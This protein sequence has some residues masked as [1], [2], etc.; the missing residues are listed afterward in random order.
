MRLRVSSEIKEQ[1]DKI[2]ESGR[3]N[4][5]AA[6]EVMVIADEMGFSELV[7]WIEENKLRYIEGIIRGFESD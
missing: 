6:E 7:C 3:T 4:M 2:R 5:Y 1:I